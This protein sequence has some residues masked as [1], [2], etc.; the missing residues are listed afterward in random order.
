L[1][2]LEDPLLVFAVCLAMVLAAYVL[3]ALSGHGDAGVD[4]RLPL[5]AL[6]TAAAGLARQKG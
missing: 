5:V 6:I 1:K 2:Y 3:L 4:L